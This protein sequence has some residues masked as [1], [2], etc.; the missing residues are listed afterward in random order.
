[1]IF[2]S[3]LNGLDIL[4]RD[5]FYL[6]QSLKFLTLGTLILIPLSWL[7]RQRDSEN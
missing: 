4:G 6:S 7:A 5:L 1:M 3:P 2:Y